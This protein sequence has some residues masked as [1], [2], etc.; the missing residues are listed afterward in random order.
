MTE[1]RGL[2]TAD[3]R[4]TA[5]NDFH[6]QGA[7]FSRISHQPEKAFFEF[8]GLFQVFAPGINRA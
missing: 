8:I 4:L 7:K 2:W 6:A 1:D 5:S 3:W